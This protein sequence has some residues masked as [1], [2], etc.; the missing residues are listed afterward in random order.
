M[1]AGASVRLACAVVRTG[2]VSG[3]WREPIV[4][5]LERLKRSALPQRSL[6]LAMDAIFA[7]LDY[8]WAYHASTCDFMDET[9]AHFSKAAGGS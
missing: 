4:N 8:A 7:E 6:Q 3:G 2:A 1:K 5:A 9:L